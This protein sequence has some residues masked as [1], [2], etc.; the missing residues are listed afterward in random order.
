MP[1]VPTVT[2]AGLPGFQLESWVALYVASGTPVA[3]IDK[4][5]SSLKTR[6]KK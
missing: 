2:E 5:S 4:L 3:V 6:V 1:N